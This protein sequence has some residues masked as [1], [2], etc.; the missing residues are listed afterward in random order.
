MHDC[1]HVLV[2]TRRNEGWW[3]LA[4]SCRS[5]VDMSAQS[6][7]AWRSVDCSGSYL[8]PFCCFLHFH[9][10]CCSRASRIAHAHSMRTLPKYPNGMN[11]LM[12][13]LYPE[14]QSDSFP[15]IIARGN[16]ALR[17]GSSAS[18]PEGLGLK[19]ASA[20]ET[21]SIAILVRILNKSTDCASVRQPLHTS[22]IHPIAGENDHSYVLRSRHPRL[23]SDF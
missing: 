18:Q 17:L 16:N 15:W 19:G 1:K 2:N 4:R 14:T 5:L 9:F 7:Q 3:F 8:H 21:A 11:M 12:F 20:D 23:Q 22:T 6:T 13:K 10:W